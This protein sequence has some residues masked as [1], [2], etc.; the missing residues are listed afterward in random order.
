M[1]VRKL[2]CSF[3]N[4]LISDFHCIFIM[5]S[6]TNFGEKKQRPPP[7]AI[8][9]HGNYIWSSWILGHSPSHQATCNF[10]TASY[11]IKKIGTNIYRRH[12]K[13]MKKRTLVFLVLLN[14]TFLIIFP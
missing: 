5:I 2:F 4:P 3:F 11:N 1:L 9:F 8:Y 7:P 12:I 6:V 13:L 10:K 14:N